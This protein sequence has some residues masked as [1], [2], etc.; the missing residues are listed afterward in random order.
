LKAKQLGLNAANI[1]S[2]IQNRGVMQSQGQ[3]T[4]DNQAKNLQRQ[5]DQTAAQI[6]NQTAQVDISGRDQSLKEVVAQRGIDAAKAAAAALTGPAAPL[7]SARAPVAPNAPS[8][9]VAPGAGATNG[10]PVN[11]S[12]FA[13]SSP[14]SDPDALEAKASQFDTAAA[15][16]AADPNTQK[17]Y[18]DR[19][20]QL[21]EAASKVRGNYF[22]MNSKVLEATEKQKDGAIQVKNNALAFRNTLFDENGK[23]RT[24]TG[25]TTDFV[26]KLAGVAE[27]YGANPGT[28]KSMLN[29]DPSKYEDL[30]MVATNMVGEMA[31]DSMG[32]GQRIAVAE[33]QNQMKGTPNTEILPRTA[34]FIIDNL[35][36]P[37][38]D[39]E[40]QR[41]GTIVN[42]DP[43]G[44]NLRGSLYNYDQSNPLDKIISGKINTSNANEDAARTTPPAGS[45]TGTRQA[46]D[47]KFYAPD[48]SRPGKY[49]M[50][51]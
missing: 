40:I 18:M 21:R 34:K 20:N 46:P 37:R 6:K 43:R 19:A 11:A 9:P 32:P 5:L 29:V 33:Y 25:P 42:Q 13:T 16:A 51:H 7:G 23:P 28:I 8:A 45:P 3:Q 12:G 14:Q 26:N 36:V 47:G 38:A 10:V 15:A 24:I 35:I 31:R 49:L 41:F 2:E 39:W 44:S 48:P 30:K 1:N 17:M 22:D 50:V 27:A 4:I